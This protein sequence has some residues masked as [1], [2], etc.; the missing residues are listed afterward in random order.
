[1]QEPV[2]GN[3][4]SSLAASRL[5]WFFWNFPMKSKRATVKLSTE[6][7][8]IPAAFTESRLCAQP[9]G[10][11]FARGHRSGN[12]VLW[13]NVHSRAGVTGKNQNVR[14]KFLWWHWLMPLHRV[15]KETAQMLPELEFSAQIMLSANVENPIFKST[16]IRMS[17]ACFS[18]WLFQFEEM[19]ESF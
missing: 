6:G 10:R 13:V 14:K 4:L 15:S 11:C 16:L 1:M 2:L 17:A 18:S 5:P 7:K 12:A 19:L 3:H 9:W 8:T